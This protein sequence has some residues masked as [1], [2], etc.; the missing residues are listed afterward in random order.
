MAKVRVHKQAQKDK[1]K[2]TREPY[3]QDRKAR[4]KQI[5][6]PRICKKQAIEAEKEL[7]EAYEQECSLLQLNKLLE[8]RQTLEIAKKRALTNNTAMFNRPEPMK[9]RQERC[10]KHDLKEIK[11]RAHY[12]DCSCCGYPR[13]IVA[14]RRKT[15]NDLWHEEHHKTFKQDPLEDETYAKAEADAQAAC[16]SWVNKLCLPS[17][18]DVGQF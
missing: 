10:R 5:R 1:K 2:R 8:A 12:A 13:L 11:K 17:S 3:T 4:A 18:F 15:E 6:K 14:K 16:P 7:R 9:K